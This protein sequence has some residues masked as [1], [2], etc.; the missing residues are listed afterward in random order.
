MGQKHS[1][2]KVEK[3]M[4]DAYLRDILSDMKPFKKK[5]KRYVSSL[6]FDSLRLSLFLFVVLC[7][8]LFSRPRA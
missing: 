6:P 7:F 5:S 2:E 8:Q 4:G 1:N 3:V